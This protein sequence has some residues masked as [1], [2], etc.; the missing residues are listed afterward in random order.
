MHA[1][2]A[3]ILVYPA[4]FGL[5]ASGCA[6]TTPTATTMAPVPTETSPA[7]SAT[8]DVTTV[9]I[10]FSKDDQTDCSSVAPVERTV[11]AAA[12][13]PQAALNQLFAGPTEAEEAE[14][15][16]SWFSEET[17]DILLSLRIE[18]NT[19]Y[20]NLQD[21]RPIIPGANSSCGSQAFFAQIET[22]LKNTAPVEQVFYAIE[23]D[24]EAF[25]E[26]M[27]LGCDPALNNCDPA[28]FATP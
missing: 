26:W 1:K 13:V 6:A 3:V 23:G 5:L 17:A 25:Y 27:Q 18:N 4:M 15:Y 14:G 9:T 2:W 7:A 20:V 8:P 24:P 12:D 22:T 10:Y 16:S 28:P 21:I 19:A 11:S